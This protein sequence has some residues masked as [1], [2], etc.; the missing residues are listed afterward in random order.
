LNRRQAFSLFALGTLVLRTMAQG[1]AG[2]GAFSKT[3]AFLKKFVDDGQANGAIACVFRR[4]EI[5]FETSEGWLDSEHKSSMRRNAIFNIA[6]LSKPITGVA[7]MILIEQ[8]QLKLEDPIER[9]TPEMAHRQVLRKPDRPLDDTYTAPHPITVADLLSMHMGLG[10]DGPAGPFDDAFRK[11]RVVADGDPDLWLKRMGELPLQFAPGERWLNDTSVDVL[12]LLIRR[13]TGKTLTVF[14]QE[15]ILGPLGMTDTGFF[16]PPEKMDRAA[17]WPE[18][19]RAIQTKPAR[20]ESGGDGMYSSAP[21][22]LRFARMLLNRGQMDGGRILKE[23]SI[24]AM[25]TDRFRPEEHQNGPFFDRYSGRGFGYTLAVRTEALAGGPPVGAFNWA[26][27][28]GVWFIADPKR[29]MVALLMAQHPSRGQN[30][31]TGVKYMPRIEEND[32]FQAAI[33][34]DLGA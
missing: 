3:R 2:A 9:W 8:G 16:V 22:Y 27:A 19:N 31:K 12:G 5:E 33:Y 1:N 29:D 32:V 25:T 7:A 24:A 4:D 23:S 34:A 21:D 17:G 30:P 28:T 11:I 6:S 26:G 20:F 14:D 18:A 10:A 15:H 13:L